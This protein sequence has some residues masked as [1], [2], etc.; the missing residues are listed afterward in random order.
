MSAP[1]LS[2]REIRLN[3]GA[4]VLFSGLDLSVSMGE[5]LCLLGRNGSGKS[6]LLKVIAG[7]VEADG[8][9]RFVQPGVHIAYLPQEPDFG[10]YDRLK[11]YVA[12]GLGIDEEDALHKV[13]AALAELNLLPDGNPKHLSGGELRKA[14]IARAFVAEPDLLLLDEPTN[15]LD[16]ATIL[17][18]EQKLAAYR[19][20]VILISHDRAFLTRLASACLWLDRG[21]VRRLDRG[22]E[23]FP[24]WMAS[25]L[26]REAE[27][28]AKLDKLI[29]EETRWS[30]AG[31]TA[32]RTRNE[33]RMRR[34]AALRKERSQRIAH[35]GTAALALDEGRTSGKLVIEAENVKKSFGDRVIIEDFSTR[36]IRGDRIGIIGPNGAG[37][38]TLLNILTGQLQPDQ[39]SIRLGTNL[40]KLVIEQKRDSLDPDTSLWETLTGGSADQVMVRGQPK[41]IIAYLKDFLFSPAQARSPVRALSGGEKNRLMLAKALTKPSN[42]LILDEPTNDLDMETLD[43]LQEILA[44][45]EGTV[46][47]VSHDRD[48]ID[49]L[50]TS[51]IVMEGDG[52][53]VE[54]AGDYSDYLAQKPRTEKDRPEPRTDRK[55]ATS[56][57]KPKSQRAARLSFKD[58][59]ALETLPKEISALEREAA[60]LEQAVADPDAYQRDPNKFTLATERLSACRSLIAE[61]EEQWLELELMRESL[62]G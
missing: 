29:A 62:E 37:K 30:H 50:V 48:F 57:E 56:S 7:L 42:L 33:G 23:A 13:E 47:L 28:T 16:I 24:D 43:L 17:W 49:R 35:Q 31:I 60:L 59:H 14:A 1:L 20:A 45:Y 9:E 3:L 61:K 39:G 25:E 38:T 8:G 18:L 32:R 55:K 52:S 27:E 34:L 54:Y 46:L 36:I 19:G 11:D 53:V 21:V 6:T 10:R 51:T 26:A 4:T 2:L 44:E 12:S 15:H 58:K 22:F 5:R 41:H 40:E